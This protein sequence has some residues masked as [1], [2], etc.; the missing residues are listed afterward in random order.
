M[1][2]VGSLVYSHS[3]FGYGEGPISVINPVCYNGYS[4][5]LNCDQNIW[6]PNTGDVICGRG[7]IQGI[8]CQSV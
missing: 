7:E 3:Y 5:I 1:V 6:N 2:I 8:A 4:S